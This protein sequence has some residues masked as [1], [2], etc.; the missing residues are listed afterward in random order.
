MT[1]PLPLVLLPGLLC[2][3]ALFRP[4][5]EAL[6]LDQPERACVVQDL[7]RHDT[8]AGMAADVL[9][10]APRRFALVGLSMGGY[11]A[12]EILRRAP[13]RVAAVMLIDTA[14]RADTPEQL[15][16]RRGLIELSEKGQFK[17]VTP[18]LLPL[19]IH[20][21]RLGDAA[22]VGTVTGMA[23]RVGQ[24]A[25][26]RQQKAIMGRIDGRPSLAAIRCPALVACGRPDI[27]T[28]PALSQEM[29]SLIP[30]ARYVPIE[31]CGHLATLEQPAAVTA[32]LRY[33]LALAG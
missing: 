5:V 18:R 28:P 8:I 25:F 21:A 10:S 14:A 2:D 23:E 33:W 27:L 26:T 22:L 20:E 1:Q 12:Q 3:Q 24:A 15:A 4:Q 32:L 16:R 30:G 17:G 9:G 11:V 13:E 6:A 29:A 31:E 7:T 19:L